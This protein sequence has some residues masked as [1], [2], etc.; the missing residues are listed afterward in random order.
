MADDAVRALL[1]I[2]EGE[3]SLFRVKPTGNMDIIELKKL[4][5]EEG[6]NTTE[7]AVLAKDLI[8]WKVRM[9]LASDSAANSPVG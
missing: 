5:R 3:S 6:I 2:I 4:I 9:T 1:C 8:L 7:R